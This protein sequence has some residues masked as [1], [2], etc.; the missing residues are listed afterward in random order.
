MRTTIAALLLGI[1]ACASPP[2]PRAQPTPEPGAPEPAPRRPA[3]PD[4][5]RVPRPDDVIVLGRIHDPRKV[6][7]RL[8]EW[9]GVGSWRRIVD[10]LVPGLGEHAAPD[11][12]YD[13]VVAVEKKPAGPLPAAFVVVS[14]GL[15]S[16]E[17][18]LGELGSST[19]LREL[20]PG[21]QRIEH[22]DQHCVVAAAAGRAPARLVCG[23]SREALE[24][25]LPYATRGL[26][27]E[28]PASDDIRVDADVARLESLHG[29]RLVQ[30]E[31][32]AVP[33]L[34]LALSR[35]DRRLER[36]VAPLSGSLYTELLTLLQDVDDI[37]ISVNFQENSVAVGMEAA[38]REDARSF[39]ARS[40][41]EMGARQAAAPEQ[42]W[43]VPRDAHFVFFS[44]GTG[45]K[46][47][48]LLRRTLAGAL[49]RAIRTPV[50]RPTIDLVVEALFPEPPLV[51]AFGLLDAPDR[52][53]RETG[54]ERLRRRSRRKLGWH[55][56][57][58]AS[59]PK[60]LEQRLDR[61]MRDYNAGPLREL[62]YGELGGL[63]R[64]LP[65]IARKPAARNLPRGTVLY[66]MVVPGKLFEDCA[67]SYSHPGK[68]EPLGVALVFVP[69]KPRSWIAIAP[70]TAFAQA[71]IHGVTSGTGDGTLASDRNA[72]DPLSRPGAFGVAA[73]TPLL[74]TL[75]EAPWA[76]PI[77][78]WSAPRQRAVLR[79]FVDGDKL[80]AEARVPRAVFER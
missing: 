55:L 63:C 34:T 80:V 52:P 1:A 76:E 64:G 10:E 72:L 3:K 15:V 39:S 30:L 57:S 37:R 20:A 44:Q 67:G 26:V 28:A 68:V 17:A 69:G 53:A 9:S 74:E 31:R 24:H 49:S 50:P 62:V 59:D 4:L 7:G 51:Y 36:A 22:P 25:L 61:G 21:V 42:L 32:W 65:K 38:L 71:L 58:V 13:V 70:D 78:R 2:Q 5:S 47:A 75:A 19:R 45:A 73:S 35:T 6:F 23:S 33:L 41:L 60:A 66:E 79:A 40:L 54:A 12:S 77:T 29:Q 56:I 27:H 8:A 18:A 16:Y 11:A 46:R 43:R 14:A 48:E